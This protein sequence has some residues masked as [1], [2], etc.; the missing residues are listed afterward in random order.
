MK[1]I[2]ILLALL[3]TVATAHAYTYAL[4]TQEQGTC[5]NVYFTP[6]YYDHY[7]IVL[8]SVKGDNQKA[9]QRT[10]GG[11]VSF[12]NLKELAIYE[13]Q[14]WGIRGETQNKIETTYHCFK[15][16]S[17]QIQPP[18]ISEIRQA[19][20]EELAY[21]EA[22]RNV[23]DMDW[24]SGIE[25]INP[26]SERRSVILHVGGKEK[27]IFVPAYGTTALAGSEFVTNGTAAVWLE[28]DEN[29]ILKAGWYKK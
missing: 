5:L 20:K 7:S 12:C 13:I 26:T 4:E 1:S 24:W 11:Y 8:Q 17:G 18:T 19:V 14:L 28:A 22:Y 9:E 15:A 25:M 3:L 21:R 2:T 23:E 29:I 10:F 27:L 16:G 6:R